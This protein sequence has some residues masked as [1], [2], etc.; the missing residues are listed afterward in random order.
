MCDV[1]LPSLQIDQNEIDLRSFL[2]VVTLYGVSM[3]Q[4]QTIRSL[5][6][7]HD[8]Q[9]RIHLLIIDNTPGEKAGRSWIDGETDYVS[10]GENKGL[11]QAYETAFHIAK[12][13]GYRFLVFL[14]QDSEVSVGF[15]RALDVVT[16]RCNSS[17]AIWC[18][19]VI[20]D[21]R[22][23]SPYSLN[24]VGWPNFRPRT[25]SNLYGINSFSVVNVRFIEL[26]GGF[27]QFYWLDCLD[28]WLYEQAHKSDW[29]I[30]RLETSV[31]HD[32][33]LVS[34]K[35]TLTRLQNI[36]FYESCFALE[37]GTGGRILGTIFRLLLRGIKRLEII[38]GMLNWVD[39]LREIVRGAGIGLERRGANKSRAKSSLSDPP[40]R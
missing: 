40:T 31:D 3:H 23:V 7:F 2:F 19:D 1:T 16:N 38:G 34:G 12:A 5:W 39:Y 9:P 4:S 30:E 10:F 18:P 35:I 11:A 15:V 28:S 26:I 13:K 36:A 33:S 24:M 17:V 21:G 27:E 37:Y 8:R 20:C 6:Q 29:H 22:P 14:D 32:L 25:G